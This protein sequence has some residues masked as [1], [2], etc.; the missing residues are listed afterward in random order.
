M[1]GMQEVKEQLGE[2]VEDL[3]RKVRE[4]RMRREQKEKGEDAKKGT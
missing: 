4:A 1:R 3:M 2:G